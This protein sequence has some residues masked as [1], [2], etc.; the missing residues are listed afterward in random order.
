VTAKW[1]LKDARRSR[2]APVSLHRAHDGGRA[3]AN[4]VRKL[5]GDTVVIVPAA[6]QLACRHRPRRCAGAF[7]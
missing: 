1:T 2:E 3:L 7:S 4:A 6:A 5:K